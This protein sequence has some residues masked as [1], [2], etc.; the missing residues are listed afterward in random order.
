MKDT[1]RALAEKYFKFMCLLHEKTITLTA[2]LHFD[3]NHPWHLHL[4]SLYCSLIELTGSA[5][6]LIKEGVCIGIPILLRSAVEAHLDFANLAIDRTYGYMLRASELKEW[7]K[8]LKESKN[9]LNP[10][11]KD[12]SDFSDTEKTLKKW[13][14]ELEDLRKKGY[15]PLSAYEKFDRANRGPVYHSV[16]NIL[17]CYSHNNLRALKTRHVNISEKLNDFEVDLY[18]PID[19]DRMLPYIDNFCGI[20]IPVTETIHQLL[21]TN[22]TR[23][24]EELKVEFHKHRNAITEQADEP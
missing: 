15:K 22:C 1:K 18:Q 7:I 19:Y 17:C 8:L 6:I 4:V 24:I 5:C 20:L 14:Q 11:L 12:I 10:F 9:G 3:K 2:E 16:Y 21:E 23:E 13:E